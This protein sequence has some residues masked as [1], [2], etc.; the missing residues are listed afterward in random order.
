L[1]SGGGTGGHVYPVLAVVAALQDAAATSSPAPSVADANQPQSGLE[2]R[3]AGTS[4]GIEAKLAPQAGLDFVAI[5]AGQVR[6]HNPFKLVRNGAKLLYGGWQARGLMR[7]WRPDAVFVTGGYACVPVVWAAH[8]QSIPVLIY[9]PDM[10]PGLAVQRL[11]RY[12]NQIAVSYPEVSRFFPDKAIVTGYPLR[13]ELRKRSSSKADARAQFDLAPDQPTILIFGGSRGARSINITT[14]NI[15]PR[16]LEVAQVIHIT[17]TLDWSLS[18]E[19]AADLSETQRNRYRPFP[20]LY[21][22]MAAAFN[23][24]DLAVARAGAATLGEFPALGLPAILIPLPISGGHQQP[25]A[26]YLAER[27]AAIAIADADMPKKLWPTLHDLLKH[28]EKL[29]AMSQASSSLA[30]PAA[31]DRIA[32]ALMTLAAERPEH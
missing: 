31:A 28:P 13:P 10:T 1:V 14:A 23:A 7:Q 9:L 30:Q 8:R 24:A 16:L 26:D 25:N 11:S 4:D 5:Q 17:G 20:Y 15:L 18:Q 3:Y 29:D 21:D 6:I 22:T 19:R 2:I 12:A 27:G 32:A